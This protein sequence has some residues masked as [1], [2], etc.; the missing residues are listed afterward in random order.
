[1]DNNQNVTEV[2][3]VT[4]AVE[5]KLAAER[6][7]SYQQNSWIDYCAIGGL[8]SDDDGHVWK[9]SMEDFATSIGSTRNTL[10]RWKITISNFN[11]RVMQRRKEL[12]VQ[13]RLVHVYNGLYLKARRGDA[14]AAA[15]FLANTDPE[16]HMPNQRIE[17]DAAGSLLDV[18][19]KARNT[20]HI[21][22]GEVVDVSTDQTS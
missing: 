4:E 20:S 10:Y 21:I 2:Q 19:E 18:L 9:M 6:L 17:H 8:R 16:F 11:E 5:A 22:E 12:G 1:M 7:L 13:S 3:N 14:P 15:L